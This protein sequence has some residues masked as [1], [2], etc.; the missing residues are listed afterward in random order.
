MRLAEDYPVRVFSYHG[1]PSVPGSVEQLRARRPF[2]LSH[3]GYARATLR[4][5]NPCALA[6][7]EA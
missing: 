3:Y 6:V 5:G 4:R 7:E 1:F 2:S